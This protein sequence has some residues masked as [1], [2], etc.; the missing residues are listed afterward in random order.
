MLI[1][2]RPYDDRQIDVKAPAAVFT[3]EA[4]SAAEPHFMAP[5]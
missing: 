5:P 2:K 1:D 4:L 3:W